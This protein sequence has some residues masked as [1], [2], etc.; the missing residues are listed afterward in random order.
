MNYVEGFVAAVPD[1]N[2]EAFRNR[3]RADAGPAPDTAAE[4]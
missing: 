3:G 4:R 2:R 1:A